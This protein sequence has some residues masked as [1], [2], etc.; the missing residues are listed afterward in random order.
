MFWFLFFFNSWNSE[1]TKF[2]TPTNMNFIG[3]QRKKIR[4]YEFK[5][6]HSMMC[7]KHRLN[8]KVIPYL[9]DHTNI[10]LLDLLI[11]FS[12]LYLAVNTIN[13]NISKKFKEK[14]N[15][16]KVSDIVKCLSLVYYMST[17]FFCILH[18]IMFKVIIWYVEWYML[19]F[20]YKKS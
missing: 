9:H 1:S 17:F 13:T 16:F 10:I 19:W 8:I 2:K 7:S 3:N 14:Q 15:L 5:F 6:F 18:K 12:L 11:P 4:I 20:L